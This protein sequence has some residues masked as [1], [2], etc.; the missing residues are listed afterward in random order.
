MITRQVDDIH[1]LVN[2]FSSFAR[3]PSPKL[4]VVNINKVVTDYIKPL[5]SSFDDV[6]IEIDKIIEK[7]YNG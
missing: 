6:T 4:K 1:H 3:M 5:I 2:E 7:L